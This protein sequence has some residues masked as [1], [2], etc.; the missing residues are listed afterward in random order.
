[1]AAYARSRIANEASELSR[2][3]DGRHTA[4]FHAACALGRYAHHGIVAESEIYNALR[5]ASSANGLA[6]KRG[7]KEVDQCIARGLRYSSGDS[8]P[9]L[10]QLPGAKPRIEP[11]WK[12]AQ[13]A[14]MAY[15]AAQL[16]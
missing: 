15:W 7:W 13:D 3:S 2:Y 10:D 14:S 8:L 12:R 5:N 4:L 11:L 9:D 6:T 1:M 16:T